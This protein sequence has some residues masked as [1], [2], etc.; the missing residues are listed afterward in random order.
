MNAGFCF[1]EACLKRN[2]LA[3]G[4]SMDKSNFSR[5]DDNIHFVSGELD[6]R[7]SPILLNSND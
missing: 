4:L 7:I 5:K 3:L 6:L 2:S 1:M